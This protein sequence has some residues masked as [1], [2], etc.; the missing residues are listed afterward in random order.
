[1]IEAFI[2]SVAVVACALYWIGRLAPSVTRTLWQ[3]AGS[4][5]EVVHAPAPLRHA[6]AGR[7]T[8]RSGSGCGGCKG[9]GK[10]GG[11]CH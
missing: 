2:V 9:C 6:V 1:M 7:I 11:G 4:V 8:T 5:L 3:G 10:D